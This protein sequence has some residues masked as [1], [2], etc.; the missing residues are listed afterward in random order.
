MKKDV[1]YKIVMSLKNKSYDIDSAK[2]GCKAGKGPKAS[3]KHVGAVC[4]AL[5]ELSF[6]STARLPDLHT[7]VTGVE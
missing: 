5:V 7:K 6:W 2:C 1:I 3:C 4:Y